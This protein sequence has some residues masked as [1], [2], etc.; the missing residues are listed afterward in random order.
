MINERDN[1]MKLYELHNRMKDLDLFTDVKLYI[2]GNKIFDGY[3]KYY[4][5][6]EYYNYDVAYFHARQ[7]GKFRIYLSELYGFNDCKLIDY[8]MCNS[9]LVS[10]DKLNI[11][12]DGLRYEETAER[13]FCGIS[14]FSNTRNYWIKGNDILINDEFP[15]L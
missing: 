15:V 9:N 6:T 5:L 11:Y 4:M 2:D 1:A 7:D 3:K 14:E 10:K 12:K 8:V 13:I